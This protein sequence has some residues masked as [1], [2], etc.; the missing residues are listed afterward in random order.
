MTKNDIIKMFLLHRSRVSVKMSKLANDLGAR[1]RRHDNSYSNPT[2]LHIIENIINAKNDEDRAH[3]EKLLSNIH[4]SKNDYLPDFFDN[5]IKDM[6]ILQLTEFIVD[7]VVE[8]EEENIRTNNASKINKEKCQNYVITRSGG[9]SEDMKSI[10][11]NT[12]DY[13][14]DSNAAILK[15]LMRSEEGVTNGTYEEE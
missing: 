6:N 11:L 14:C 8:F 5:G 2:E 4:S 9:I 3:N 15:T 10:I 13:I 1:G 12:V 7:K